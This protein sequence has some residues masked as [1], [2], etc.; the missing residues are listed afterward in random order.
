MKVHGK[1]VLTGI[2]S[3]TVGSIACYS[4]AMAQQQPQQQQ[5]VQY[6]AALNDQLGVDSWGNIETG[7]R[8]YIEKPSSQAM[9]WLAPA[10]GAA[11]P[12]GAAASTTPWVAVPA[13]PTKDNIA[14]YIEYGNVPQGAYLDFLNVGG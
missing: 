10:T 8:Y 12:A 4:A 3:V 6:P 11:N 9:P 7:D 5:P 14:K 1:I 13:G 2:L